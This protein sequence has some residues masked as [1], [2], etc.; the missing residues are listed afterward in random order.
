MTLL[1]GNESRSGS[2]DDADG[3]DGK[4]A[5]LGVDP[6]VDRQLDTVWRRSTVDAK[7]DRLAEAVELFRAEAPRL[8]RWGEHLAEV[9]VAGGRLLVA[10]NGGSAAEAQHLSA[11]LVGKLRDDR[12]AYSAI[13]LSAETS[14]LTAIGNDYGYE[15]VFARQV[16]AHG[17]PGDVL[18]LISTSGR[19]KNLLAAAAAARELDIT[20]WAMTGPLPNPLGMCCDDV[21][22][23]PCDSQ[24]AQELHLVAVHVL[25]EQIEAA[26][27]ATEIRAGRR[28]GRGARR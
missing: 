25:C 1:S 9:L 13:A 19:S 27:P 2:A 5:V 3:H 11:E 8:A 15:H 24:T 26:L 22:A 23:I 12:P 28:I 16:Q 10:G 21:L 18:V 4:P 7:L 17:R 14:S 20:S 6:A